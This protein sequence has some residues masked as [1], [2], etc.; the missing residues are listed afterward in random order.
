MIQV[1]G[2]LCGFGA[3]LLAGDIAYAAIIAAIVSRYAPRAILLIMALPCLIFI[4]IAE[5]QARVFP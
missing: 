1:G 4:R 3:S 2:S 5:A